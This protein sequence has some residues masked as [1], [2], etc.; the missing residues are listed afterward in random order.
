LWNRVLEEVERFTHHYQ[1]SRVTQVDLLT[2]LFL[3]FI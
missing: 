1:E 2:L 3:V